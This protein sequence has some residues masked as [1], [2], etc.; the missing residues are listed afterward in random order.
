[1]SSS[2][3]TYLP[4]DISAFY[5]WS[6]DRQQTMLIDHIRRIQRS[7]SSDRETMYA[8]TLDDKS[9]VNC[10]IFRSDNVKMP[11]SYS[12]VHHLSDKRFNLHSSYFEV[13]ERVFNETA[14]KQKEPPGKTHQSYMIQGPEPQPEPEVVKR[15]VVQI[16]YS[17]LW[18]KDYNEYKARK[19]DEEVEAMFLTKKKEMEVLMQKM[20]HENEVVCLAPVKPDQMPTADNL[21]GHGPVM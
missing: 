3:G 4:H 17:S 9:D 16:T 7:Q 1:M 10:V 21:T 11:P 6:K 15:P 20:E 12:C 13:L 8:A 18:S 14:A 5:V 19:N 2:S